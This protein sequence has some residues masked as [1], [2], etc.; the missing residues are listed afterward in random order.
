MFFLRN[1]FFLCCCLVWTASAQS[2]TGP[3][4]KTPPP[5]VI[6]SVTVEGAKIYEVAGI[7]KVLGLSAGEPAAQPTLRAAQGRLLQTDLFS[8]VEY[9]F[10]YSPSKPPQYDVTFKVSE[11]EQVF[12]LQ[13]E[14]LGVP[15]DALRAYL[16]DHVSLYSDRIP[17]TDPVLRRYAE[18]AQAFVWQTKPN[19]KVKAFVA[20]DNPDHVSVVIRPDRPLPRIAGVTV[21]GNRAIETPVLMRALNEVAVGQRLSDATMRQLLETTV[22]PV[23]AAK[24]YVAVSFPKMT[25]EKSPENEGYIAHITIQEGPV[26]HFGSSAFRGGSFTPE[27]VRS[28]MHYKRGDV[29]DSTKAE[30]LRADLVKS[31]R[32]DGHLDAK[33]ELARAEDDKNEAINLTF[34]ITPGPVYTFQTLE[35]HGLDIESE[36]EIR[37]LWAPKPGKPFNPEYPDYFLKRVREMSLF[38]NLGSTHSSFTPEESSHTVIVSL[39]FQGA[40]GEIQKARKRGM[41]NPS[42]PDGTQPQ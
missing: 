11:Y 41:P 30:Q 29:F 35:V 20:N 24:G 25:M 31:M 19:L 9:G 23:Y 15:D 13:F 2:S 39:Y 42:A 38:D 34:Q 10:R 36:P 17:P 27:D 16:R 37:K 14:D 1:I 32:H 7:K 18:A 5:G 4:S 40:Q 12:P 3:A 33:A 6:R 26:F 22:K 8:S 28:M 21:A